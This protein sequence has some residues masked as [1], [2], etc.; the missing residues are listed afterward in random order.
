MIR[1]IAIAAAF[2]L[3]FHAQAFAT[4]YFSVIDDLPIPDGMTEM[5][6]ESVVFD[7][8]SGKIV[9]AAAEGKTTVAAVRAYYRTALPPLGWARRSGDGAGGDRFVRDGQTLTLDYVADGD[10]VTVRVRLL[11]SGAQK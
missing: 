4:A 3:C 8:P 11:P 10:K 5:A 9:T 6:D 1:R 2:L 7:S